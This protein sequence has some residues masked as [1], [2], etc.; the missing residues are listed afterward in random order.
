VR[1]QANSGGGAYPLYLMTPNTKNG[2]HSQFNNL[3]MIREVSAG[4]L[5]AI[6][7]N[8]A[9]KRGIGNG[10]LVRVF[11]NRGSFEVEARFDYG[12]KQGCVNVTNGWWSGEGG[13]VNRCSKGRETDMA[14]GAAFHDNLVDVQSV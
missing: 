5:V 14:F 2:I 3:E 13:C 8:D 11:N 7:P 6:H 4:P 1:R 9:R 10:S 12:I